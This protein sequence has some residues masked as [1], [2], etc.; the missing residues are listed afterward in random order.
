LARVAFIIDH[1][2][3]LLA[4]GIVQSSGSPT[5]DQETLE[6]LARAQPMPTPPVGLPIANCR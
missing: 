2:G 5:L 1:G 3:R 4:S 6:M